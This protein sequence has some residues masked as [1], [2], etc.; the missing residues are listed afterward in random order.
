MAHRLLFGQL[1]EQ[2][3]DDVGGGGGAGE[4]RPSPAEVNASLNR[5]R[6]SRIQQISNTADGRR[7]REMSDVDGER[8]TGRFAGGELDESPEAREAA[9]AREEDLAAQALQEQRERDEQAAELEQEEGAARRLQGEGAD[10]D[11]EPR[12][13]AR[14]DADE[15]DGA[16]ERV[17]DG[18]RYYRTMVTGTEKWLTLKELREGVARGI[19]TEET[20]QRAQ[21][22][23]ASASQTRVTPKEPEVEVPDEKD[24]ENIILSAN[25]GDE[26]AVRKLAT[27]VRSGRSGPKPEDLSRMVSQQIATQREV[28]RAEA[29][30]QDLLGDERLAPMFRVNL[31]GFAREKPNTRIQDAYKSV[32]EKMRKDFAPML[33][34]PEGRPRAPVTKV[35][36]KR[37]IVVPP[38]SAGRQP[39]RQDE[40]HEVP[41]G[42]QID[43]IARSR[44]QV[45]AHRIRRS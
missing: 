38:R 17:I 44:G 20:L 34:T 18:V 15:D 43:A 22:A 5:Q 19:A 28:D 25:M 40:D 8:V 35:D 24:L 26:E 2:A 31:A 6:L 11:G 39:A 41:V 33:T 37:Q 4:R 16:E 1:R 42:D 14:T 30:V 23:L 3:G 10:D 32:A 13:A 7:A 36:R 45:R 27:I 9:A 12:G 29:S 21:A